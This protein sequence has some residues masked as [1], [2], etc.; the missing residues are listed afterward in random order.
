MHLTHEVE[1]WLPEDVGE[2][3]W[4]WVGEKNDKG[5]QENCSVWIFLNVYVHYLGIDDD[6]T[7]SYIGQMYQIVRSNYVQL[8]V[9]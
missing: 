9:C 6:F 1:Q 3:M 4:G 7:C 8:I 2:G 5:T